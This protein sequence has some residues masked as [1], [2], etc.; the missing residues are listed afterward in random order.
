M[1]AAALGPVVAAYPELQ[2]EPTAYAGT[3]QI[4]TS[5]TGLYIGIFVALPFTEWLYK[6]LG[7]KPAPKGEVELK[8]PVIK[9]KGGKKK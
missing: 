4:L 2:T 6:R 8:T 1:M 9:T 3:S 5:V 7:G